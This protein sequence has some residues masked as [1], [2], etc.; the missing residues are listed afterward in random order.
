MIAFFAQ[1]GFAAGSGFP[2]LPNGI[3][4]GG[5]VPALHQLGIEEFGILV[6][7]IV[8][9]S[10]SFVTCALLSRAFGGILTKP[11]AADPR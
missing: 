11:S 10:L 3:L 2:S 1:T 9:F 5:G 6:V 8:V 4:F 7:L